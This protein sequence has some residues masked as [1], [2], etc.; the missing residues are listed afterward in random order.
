VAYRVVFR[1]QARAEIRDAVKWYD[2]QR[3]GL[4]DE[5]FSAVSA[6]IELIKSN[7]FQYQRIF[8]NRRRTVVSRFHFN[9]IYFVAGDDVVI[10]ACL[11]GRRSPVR[12]INRR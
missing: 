9:L 5:F 4:G 8:K 3:V 6:S 7:P 1:D 12:W 10:V 11:H 2:D